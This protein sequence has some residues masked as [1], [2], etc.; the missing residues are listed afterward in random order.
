MKKVVV[1][2][3]QNVSWFNLIFSWKASVHVSSNC[4]IL[5]K[6]LNT[7]K[8]TD[9]SMP[10]ICLQLHD[11]IMAWFSQLSSHIRDC[12]NAKWMKVETIISYH[13]LS[14]TIWMGLNPLTPMS[15]Q[16]RTFPH[17]INTISNRQVMRIKKNINEGM[18]S[19]SNTKFSKQT[20]WEW[21]QTGE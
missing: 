6:I 17:N 2:I 13:Q 16:D 14:I 20:W 8:I 11:L 10:H 4:N 18:I 9:I 1:K 15:D 19:W 5:T 7:I 21:W 12:L 3:L